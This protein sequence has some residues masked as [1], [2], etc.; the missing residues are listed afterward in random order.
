MEIVG[1]LALGLGVYLL[2]TAAQAITGFGL[3]LLAVPLLIPIVGPVPAIVSSVLVSVALCARAWWRERDAVDVPRLTRASV[4]AAGGLPVGLVLLTV[5]TEAQLAVAVAAAVVVGVV[6]LAFVKLPPVGRVG[7][8][9]GGFGSG[10]LLTSTG[11][12]GP[13]L[14]ITF[15]AI[16]MPPRTFRATLQASFLLQDLVAILGFLVVSRIDAT[17][18]W[19][20]FGGILGVPAGWAVGDKV[21]GLL[22]AQ[23]F[24][25]VVL[26]GLVATAVSSVVMVL[27]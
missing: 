22:P 2:A 23:T 12:N 24:R 15:Q 4:A 16:G 9:V 14:V 10:A 17:A 5:L 27:R 26:A 25:K 11:L 8:V 21:F 19:V 3:A 13:P 6:M 1:L 7:E 20:A 18:C